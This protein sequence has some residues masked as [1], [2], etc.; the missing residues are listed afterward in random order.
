MSI[1]NSYG[2][3]LARLPKL[4]MTKRANLRPHF[5]LYIP[6]ALYYDRGELLRHT[7]ATKEFGVRN[8]KIFG[9]GTMRL[10]TLADGA[11]DQ[12]QFCQMVDLFF[13]PRLY[14]F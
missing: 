4:S 9:F 14:L 1:E 12:A 3:I 2:F 6:L 5:D 7:P 10:P 11:I 13:G 8:M